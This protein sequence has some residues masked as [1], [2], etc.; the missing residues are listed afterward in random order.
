MYY[1]FG[2]KVYLISEA[3][4]RKIQQL[5]LSDFKRTISFAMK[6]IHTA[7]KTISSKRRRV[8]LMYKESCSFGVCI[9]KYKYLG[10]KER[11]KSIL[12]T[13]FRTKLLTQRGHVYG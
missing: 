7:R 10:H 5:A 1:C 3:S 9:F 4:K 13:E 2:R 11:T 12:Y 6:G 8:Q